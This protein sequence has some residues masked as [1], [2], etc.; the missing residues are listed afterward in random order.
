MKHPIL[1]ASLL[2]AMLVAGCPKQADTE[3]KPAAPLGAGAPVASAN[4]AANAAATTATDAGAKRL[5]EVRANI[6]AAAAAPHIEQAPV[7]VNELTVAKGRLAGVQP[8]PAEAAAAAERRALV[9]AGRAAEARTNAETAANRGRTDAA[10]IVELEAAAKVDRARADAAC[11][12]FTEQAARNMVVQ[13]K[14]IDSALA[15]QRNGVLKTQVGWLNRIGFG[16][17]SGAALVVGLGIGFGGIAVIRRVVP[18]AVALTVIGLFAFGAAQILGAWWFLPA[19][20]VAG[21]AAAIWFGVWAWRHYKREDLAQELA[22]RAAKVAAVA[23]TAVPVLDAAYD[24]AEQPIKDWMDAHIFDRLSD[25]MR[26]TP[27]MKA[28]V[29]AI[30]AETI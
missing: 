13:Q 30:R 8:D 29:H 19:V 7:A 11:I 2:A 16:C 14:A 1:L 20:G 5:A 4:A 6:D 3:A 26:K 18:L 27:E 25:I 21:G 24:Q 28:T 12:A 23:Q 17:L 15:A 10:R 9:E 22:S